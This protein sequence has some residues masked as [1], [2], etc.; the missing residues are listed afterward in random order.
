[1]T[2]TTKTAPTALHCPAWCDGAHEDPS[3]HRAILWAE[4]LDEYPVA[5]SLFNYD[6]ALGY[7]VVGAPEVS[8][9]LGEAEVWLSLSMAANLVRQLTEAIV[10]AAEATR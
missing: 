3:Y 8:L 7:D 10:K 1:M 4:E 2:T 6:E 5:V 9:E